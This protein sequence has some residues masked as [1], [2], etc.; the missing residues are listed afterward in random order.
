VIPVVGGRFGLVVGYFLDIVVHRVPL[1][2]TVVWP[3]SGCPSCGA[4]ISAWDNVPAVSYLTLRGRCWNC[5]VRISPRYS[6]VEALTGLL[7][8]LAAYEFDS[9]GDL[10]MIP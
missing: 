8:G 6:V 10:R 1:R 3:S 2:Q 4:A 5:K 9:G 7:F